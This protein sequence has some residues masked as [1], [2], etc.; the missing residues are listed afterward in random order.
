[1]SVNPAKVAQ[2][3]KQKQLLGVQFTPASVGHAVVYPLDMDSRANLSDVF[4]GANAGLV[5]N[6]IKLTVLDNSRSSRVLFTSDE[7]K[8]LAVKA[9][10]YVATISAHAD[11]LLAGAAQWS[12]PWPSNT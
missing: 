6:G 11:A 3:A 12:D 7:V 8:A 1:M 9:F 10:Q 5:P 2:V 4:T